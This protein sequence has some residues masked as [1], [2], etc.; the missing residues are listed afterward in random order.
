MW[1]GLVDGG[2]PE[3][4]P[5]YYDAIDEVIEQRK[6]DAEWDPDSMRSALQDV[7]RGKSQGEA[8]DGRDFSQPLLSKRFSDVEEVV[9]EIRRGREEGSRLFRDPVE[10]AVEDFKSFFDGLNDKYEMGISGRVVQMMVDELQD[11]QQLPA[12]TFVAEFLRGAKSGIN[13]TDVDYVKRRYEAWLENYDGVASSGGLPN[14][15]M[16][17]R[18]ARPQGGR[19]QTPGSMNGGVPIGGSQQGPPQMGRGQRGQH[20]QQ[21]PHP[22]HP[23]QGYGHPHGQGPPQQQGQQDPPEDP[24]VDELQESV[25][26]LSALVG[27]VMEE[28]DQQ[29][30]N[31]VT[32]TTPDGV[33]ADMPMEQAVEMGYIGGGGNEPDFIEK[34]AQ[35]QEAGLIPSEDDFKDDDDDGLMET[36]SMLKEMGVIDDGDG[37]EMADAIGEA[38]NS[39]GQKQ[40]QAQQQMS[41]NFASVMEQMQQMQEADDDE[42]LTLEDV[43]S[44]IE[45]KLTKS[46]TEQIRDEMDERFSRL[47]EKVDSRD[48]HHRE[49]TDDPDYLKTDREMEFREKQLETLNENLQT[50]PGAIAG[51][52]REGFVPALK[53]LQHMDGGGGNPLWDPPGEGQ[54]GQPTFRPEETEQQAASHPVSNGQGRTPSADE[55]QYPDRDPD[56]SENQEADDEQMAQR[57]PTG[58]TEED[59]RDV[60]AK[61][62]LDSD[63]EAEQ[64]EA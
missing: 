50:L 13:G 60:R 18:G 52:V 55:R 51:S 32:I 1:V 2:M 61:L 19:Q 22:Q 23:Q 25:E 63:D 12:P 53:E 4:D 47:M 48:R 57:E 54:R 37:D 44:V 14:S 9:E 24:R 56:R 5:A 49:G 21:Q 16:G 17:G 34:L 29:Q 40:L 26:Q 33:T 62:N 64:V 6:E 42:D 10:E 35:A 8:A 30:Q 46:E 43:E 11:Q 45:K 20:P 28:E 15:G 41:D 38:I 31:M 27:Q 39:L 59:A 36:I 7:A 58:M 3:V